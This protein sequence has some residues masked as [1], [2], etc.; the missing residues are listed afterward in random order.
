M[1]S[2]SHQQSNLSW[3]SITPT[4]Q[5]P[6]MTAGRDHWWHEIVPAAEPADITPTYSE[7]PLLIAYTSGTT[8]RPKGAVHVHG[9]LTLK[10]AQEGAFQLDIHRD[11]TVMWATDMGWI[12]GPWMV[13]AGLANGAAIAT[14]DGAPNHPG[15]DRIWQVASELEITVLGISPTLVRALQPYG[16]D[17]ARKH[18]LT[19]FE[20]LRFNR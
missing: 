20:D 18:D 19:K 12:M 5:T 8:G 15:P 17:E 7:D 1:Q 3:W 4:G 11:D 2:T 9:G 10:L 16:A 6:P 14:Y 13:V